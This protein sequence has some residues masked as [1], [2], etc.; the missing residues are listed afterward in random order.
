MV[1]II[2]L[3]VEVNFEFVQG[4]IVK[5]AVSHVLVSL[6]AAHLREKVICTT[7]FISIEQHAASESVVRLKCRIQLFLIKRIWIF[8]INKL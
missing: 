6:E 4:L 5:R 8:L 1:A 7:P 2:V 3:V